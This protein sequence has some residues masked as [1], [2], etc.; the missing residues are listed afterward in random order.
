MVAWTSVEVL[1]VMSGGWGNILKV[2]S[3]D[4]WQIGS[5]VWEKEKNQSWLQSFDLDKWKERACLKKPAHLG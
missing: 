3:V 1:E 5:E 4:P 2:E